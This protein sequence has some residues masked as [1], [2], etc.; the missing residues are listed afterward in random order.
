M[1]TV[2]WVTYTTEVH[3][4]SCRIWEIQDQATGHFGF[5]CELSSQFADCH[6]L[7]VSPHVWW[8]KNNLS[9][10]SSYKGPTP[11]MG[12][13]PS[14]PYLTPI[15]FQRPH[16][17]GQGGQGFKIWIWEVCNHSAHRSGSFI[18]LLS[19]Q[20][21]LLCEA[22]CFVSTWW[23]KIYP[24]IISTLK[25]IAPAGVEH[26]VGWHERTAGD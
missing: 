18:C 14:W 21:F 26:T 1:N 23:Y 7:T 16:L 24:E 25:R 8:G 12:A 9:D 19:F 3:V 10:V 15:T 2:D 5:R 20:C 11:I 17:Q 22:R 6:L 13:P 4:C